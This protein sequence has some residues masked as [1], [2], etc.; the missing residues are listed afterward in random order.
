MNCS[1]YMG[2][3]LLTHIMKLWN[4]TIYQRLRIIASISDG[5]FVSILGFEP[6]M[7]ILSPGLCVF[8]NY[9]ED[10]MHLDML[11][12]DIEGIYHIVPSEVL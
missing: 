10:N 4:R 12:V 1:N 5:Q 7:S 11:F 9:R 3:K 8:E 6:R 2:I